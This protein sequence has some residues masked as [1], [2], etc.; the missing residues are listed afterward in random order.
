MTIHADQVNVL[1]VDDQ[2]AKL[3]A[4][5][6]ILREL[7]ENLIKVSSGRDALEQLLKTDIAIVLIDVCMPELDGFEL[8]AMIREHPR[9]AKTAIIFIS[10]IHLSSV[11]YLRGYEM[12]AVDYVPVPVVPEVLRAK[13][14]VFAEL[15][16]KTRQLER[17]NTELEQRVAD[18]TADL[19]ASN[20]LL[21][22]SERRRSLALAAGQMG[23]WEFDVGNGDLKWD[24]GQCRIFGVPGAVT[25]SLDAVR[26]LIHPDDWER[27]RATA[28]SLSTDQTTHQAEFRVRRPD[29]GLRW[30][31]GSVAAT[32]GPN[33]RMV[34]LGG[35]TSDITERKQIEERQALLAREVDHR[36]RNALAIIQA[37][38]RLTRA[39]SIPEYKR[40][41]EGRIMALAR[42]HTLLS[43]SRWSGADFHTLVADELA[44]Y[45]S[46]R[47]GG[48]FTS[49]PSISL[50]P[51]TAQTLALVL[52]ELATNAAKYGALS[53]NSGALS[54][55]W[56][57]S[58]GKLSLQWKEI[59]APIAAPSPPQG[60]GL[61]LISTSIEQQL[62][63][64]VAFEWSPNGL[65]CDIVVPYNE[66]SNS[67]SAMAA[68]PDDEEANPSNFPGKQGL[69]VLL[70]E[71]EALVAMMM[72][73]LLANLGCSV[74][75]PCTTTKAALAAAEDESID[76]AL[77]DVNLGAELV[78]PV[79]DRLAARGAPFV[80][81]TGYDSEQVDGRFR[82]AMVLQKP[83]DL[84][85]LQMAL[86]RQQSAGALQTRQSVDADE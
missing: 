51:I 45:R 33:G 48:I 46:E 63:G 75:G 30:C 53:V 38:V 5:D 6:V 19:E 83:V 35:V 60:F 67:M 80:F 20:Q 18:R 22:Q 49:G 71:D 2:P 74:V 82:N 31:I 76:L 40:T 17:L 66:A 16:R 37:I 43:D 56:E 72:Q 70:V 32:F 64:K 68:K 44:P 23:S 41:V 9:F 54:L 62:A 84:K 61:R 36:A 57:V 86:A 34:R 52:H 15:H 50:E 55:A 14:R 73:D 12:G 42:A 3:L 4:Y 13:V 78:Y 24:P 27:L 39:V 77:L 58:A 10:A 29:G 11:D 1:L 25:P 7:G 81:L 65:C 47:S 59:G 85:T 69:R 26:K 8:A 21:L 28:E 79:A